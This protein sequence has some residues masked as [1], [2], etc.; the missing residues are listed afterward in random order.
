MASETRPAASETQAAAD[1]KPPPP[2]PTPAPVAVLEH[3]PNVP[4]ALP[5]LTSSDGEGQK[6]GKKK[7]KMTGTQAALQAMLGDDEDVGDAPESEDDQVSACF[8]ARDVDNSGKIEIDELH[9]I[10]AE[11]DGELSMLTSQQ[12]KE[13]VR[14]L[15]KKLDADGSGGLDLAEFKRFYRRV[16]RSEQARRQFAQKALDEVRAKEAVAK[17]AEAVF[18][19]VDCDA[20]G[21]VSAAEISAL[22][23]KALGEVHDMLQGTSAWD[24]YV[25]DVIKRGD[26][27]GDAE[28]SLPEFTVFY[29]KCLASDEVKAAYEKRVMLRLNDDGTEM[30]TV[31]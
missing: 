7:P 10:L 1:S 2:P 29:E 27:D 17:T 20:S 9:D 26:K 14:V 22:L 21:K 24:A 18:M 30:E 25:A 12:Y 4:N 15:F 23:A 8:A 11:L 16:L 3:V 19:E 31:A 13:Y 28:W 6:K 5:S